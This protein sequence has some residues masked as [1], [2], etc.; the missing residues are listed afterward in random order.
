MRFKSLLNL[1]TINRASSA[2]RLFIL[3]FFGVL[4]KFLNQ[5]ILGFESPIKLHE[6]VGDAEHRNDK[7]TCHCD[8]L[9]ECF[10]IPNSFCRQLASLKSLSKQDGFASVKELRGGQFI[11][12]CVYLLWTCRYNTVFKGFINSVNV[13]FFDHH[14]T[15]S[16]LVSF[17]IV[18][19]IQLLFVMI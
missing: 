17:Y 6:K 10:A 18:V 8:E 1:S 4:V 16:Q 11:S 7:T 3:R 2:I 12:K 9:K 14:L 13:C 19:S 5:R 15:C